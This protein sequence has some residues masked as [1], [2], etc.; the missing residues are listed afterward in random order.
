[1]AAVPKDVDILVIGGGLS[2]LSAALHACIAH[3]NISVLVVE[4]TDALGGSSQYSSGM[5]WAPRSV[6]LAHK[7][8]SFGDPELQKGIVEG[9][10]EA[11][12]WLRDQGIRVSDAFDGIMSIGVGYPMDIHGLLRLMEERILETP[13]ARIMKES[14]A[15]SLSQEFQQGPVSGATIVRASDPTTL[16]QVNSKSTIIATGGFQGNPRLTSTH[17]GNGADNIFIRS[18]RGNTGDGF[19]MASAAGAGHSRGMGTFYGHLL[20]SPLQARDVD[21][22]SFLAIA[23]FQSGRGVLVNRE[24]RRFCDETMGDE[25]SNQEV[26]RQTGRKAYLLLNE[27]VH[28]KYAVG[29][30]WPNA[31]SI[32]RIEKAKEVGGQVASAETVAELI[33]KLSEW[34]VPASSLRQTLDGFNEAASAHAE[35][36]SVDFGSLDAPIGTNEYGVPPHQP[37][38]DGSGPFWAIEVQPSLTLTYGGIKI[39]TKAE[40]LTQYGT[41]IGGLFI[42]GIDA[43]GFSNYRYCAGLALAFVTGKWAGTNAVAAARAKGQ[44]AKI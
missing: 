14:W 39:N 27:E 5:F 15:V 7:E 28:Q 16:I 24:G 21:P 6:E 26:A 17:I 30:P 44:L 41:P 36:K 25:V 18:N 32:D 13:N 4:K 8:I 10:S 40:A 38:V 29:A 2:G 35:G 11:V 20:P 1:M 43:G 42:A 9:H 23:Q 22:F 33:D 34:G 31:G 19:T 37:F 3:P 12:Q